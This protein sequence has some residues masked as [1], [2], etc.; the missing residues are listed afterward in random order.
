MKKAI[1][2]LFLII[3]SYAEY[4]FASLRILYDCE[5][6]DNSIVTSPVESSPVIHHRV[7]LNGSTFI[8][9]VEDG[10]WFVEEVTCTQ[11]G[12]TLKVIKFGTSPT[13]KNIFKIKVIAPNTYK[14]I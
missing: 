7:R 4:S 6:H 1:L 10:E 8:K 2:Y 13:L 11:T 9:E 14:I 3:A 12:F 5:A